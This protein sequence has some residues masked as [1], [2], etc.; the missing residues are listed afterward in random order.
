MIK[1]RS[2]RVSDAQTLLNIYS[3]YVLDTTITFEN[4]VP[5][6]E[7]FA[8]RIET[9]SEKYP[10]LVAEKDG[11]ILGYAYA[12]AYNVRSA[13]QWTAETSIYVDGDAKG[14]GIGK[15]LYQKLETYLTEQGVVN[16]LACITED[17]Q[18]SVK[19]HEKLGYDYIG[20]FKKV[21]FK[22]GRWLDIVWMQKTLNDPVSNMDDLK[23]FKKI[24]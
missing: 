18:G 12:S 16:L 13:Y 5:T 7:E 10:Y 11:K 8:E 21:G 14:E 9:I 20:K 17:N 23:Y 2:A 3:P 22:F 6:I 1:I 19:F 15:L 24:G 4:D